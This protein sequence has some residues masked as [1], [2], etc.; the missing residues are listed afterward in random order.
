MSTIGLI[1]MLS[2]LLTAAILGS[3]AVAAALN[4]KEPSDGESNSTVG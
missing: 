1:V 4:P 2:G 3:V